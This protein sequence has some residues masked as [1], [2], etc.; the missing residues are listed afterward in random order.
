MARELPPSWIL[1]LRARL[2]EPPPTRL[3]AEESRRAAVLVPLFVDAQELWVLLARRSDELP[4]HQGQIAFPGGSLE[5]GE[6]PWEG[7]LREAREEIGLEP[8]RVLRLGLLDEASTP[9]GFHIIPCVGAVPYPVETVIDE[10]EI[11]E[12]FA[13]PLS[14][15]ASPQLVEQQRVEIDGLPREITIFHVG[16]HRIWGLTARVLFNLL[17][18]LGIAPA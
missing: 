7:A 5:L 9:S 11:A 3:P 15:L 12:V 14:A 10:G 2:E 18:R 16:R 6:S 1:E 4:H 8:A 13:V 17:E